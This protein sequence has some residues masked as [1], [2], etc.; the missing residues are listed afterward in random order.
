MESDDL[1]KAL[2]SMFKDNI[3][4]AG[5]KRDATTVVARTTYARLEV[6][7][8]WYNHQKPKSWTPSLQEENKTN[9]QEWWGGHN[10]SAIKGPRR[11]VKDNEDDSSSKGATTA[12]RKDKR[13]FHLRGDCAK[14][15]T[16]N[17]SLQI[18]RPIT[19]EE[20]E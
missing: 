18:D 5:K 15:E 17:F 9:K 11:N 4:E 2:R 19:A 14:G 7:E 13:R 12:R 10:H 20:V 8:G 6:S 3:I 1:P 16:C